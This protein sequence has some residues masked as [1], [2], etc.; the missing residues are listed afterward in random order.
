MSKINDYSIEDLSKL[1]KDYYIEYE[2]YFLKVLKDEKIYD[3]IMGRY[4]ELGFHYLI[5]TVF[6]MTN[7]Q[8]KA[9][10]ILTAFDFV[11]IHQMLNK[12]LTLNHYN[13]VKKEF[14]IHFDFNAKDED[15]KI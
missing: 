15:I 14:N 11:Y 6:E 3:E 13:L 7:N 9:A 4:E 8:N 2:D 12:Y 1:I 5:R 10:A